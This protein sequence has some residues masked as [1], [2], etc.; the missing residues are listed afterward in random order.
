[1]FENL[2]KLVQEQAVNAIVNNPSVPNEKNEA[3]IGAA[4]EGI[5]NHLRNLGENGGLDTLMGIFKNGDLH[6]NPEISNMAGTVAGKLMDKIGLEPA[7]AN[8]I[9][10]ELVP[11]V[12]S[13]F[14]NKTNDPNDETFNLQ[15]II[16]SV[17]GNKGGL[18]D[19]L[20]AVKNLF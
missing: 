4:S 6:S 16:G 7:Q 14:V 12:M 9:V 3:A 2:L 17:T 18:N 5:M 15:D 1:M 10:Q 20:G 19:V 11:K 13:Q 8:G